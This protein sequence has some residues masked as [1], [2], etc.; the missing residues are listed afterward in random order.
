MSQTRRRINVISLDFDGC[1]F[2][3][4]YVYSEFPDRLIRHN[5]DFLDALSERIAAENFQKVWL[6]VGSNRQDVYTDLWNAARVNKGS[7]APALQQ[8]LAAF[9]SQPELKNID[10]DIDR[11]L[12][13]DLYGGHKP[14]T[15]FDLL[16][17]GNTKLEGFP[18]LF[19]NSKF[20][21][22]YAQMHKLALENSDA[23]IVFD[24]YD[25]NPLIL[26]A[27][28]DFLEANKDF[29]PENLQLRLHQY[30]GDAISDNFKPIKGERPADPYY[31]GNIF[32]FGE[33][34]GLS[35][36]LHLAKFDEYNFISLLKDENLEEF[37]K[38]RETPPPPRP[39]YPVPQYDFS[40]EELEWEA[41]FEW[42]ASVETD[43][44]DKVVNFAIDT[45]EYVRSLRVWSLFRRTQT[46]EKPLDAAKDLPSLKT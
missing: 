11:F 4:N 6:M 31:E 46:V 8:L 12:M 39:A 27:L 38:L 24:F 1:I 19:D 13:G 25:D 10:I 30:D 7:C 33:C 2:N 32:R 16:L 44:L 20:T 40:E 42:S 45:V 3:R 18:W 5:Q 15:T 17:G 9:K 21:L 28:F 35:Y 37:R 26:Q 14:G 23:D 41:G 43:P 34:A 29:V 22:L 36:L